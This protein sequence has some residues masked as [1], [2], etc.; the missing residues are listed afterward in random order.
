MY[1]L[2]QS[3]LKTRWFLSL[4]TLITSQ[5]LFLY[6]DSGHRCLFM[7]KKHSTHNNRK[8]L[9]VK[10]RC[11]TFVFYVNRY[12]GD[13]WQRDGRW[14]QF[15]CASGPLFKRM[16]VG[17]EKEERKLAQRVRTD[18]PRLALPTSLQRLSIRTRES[19]AFQTNPSL[20]TTG[21]KSC[22]WCSTI[23]GKP[24]KTGEESHVI[25]IKNV[26]AAILIDPGL[27]LHSQSCAPDKVQSF[28]R[29]VS[30]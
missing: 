26:A 6:K 29:P 19:P 9:L 5:M 8:I 4:F 17:E 24:L 3:Q 28:S 11:F 25:W 21:T 18:T 23:L 12:A 1:I 27:F 16:R 14:G 13:V 20:H 15:G 7:L 22:V 30:V 10:W 2:M